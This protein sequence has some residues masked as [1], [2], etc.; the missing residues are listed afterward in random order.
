MFLPL[1]GLL[2]VSEGVIGFI[3]FRFLNLAQTVQSM[4]ESNPDLQAFVTSSVEDLTNTCYFSIAVLGVAYFVFWL[5]HSHR[6]F[7]PMIPIGRQ[8]DLMKEGN[9]QERITLRRN[10]QFKNLAEKINQLAEKIQEQQ[11]KN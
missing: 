6:V 2:A 4:A 1:A 5:F 10:D 8:L 7:G 3:Y 11:E 9:F